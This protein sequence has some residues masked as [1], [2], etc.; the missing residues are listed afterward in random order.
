MCSM[1]D[2]TGYINMLASYPGLPTPAFVACSTNAGEGKYA[3]CYTIMC[4]N[5]YANP[6]KSAGSLTHTY[7][8]T[9][10]RSYILTYSL[11]G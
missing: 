6:G 3:M 7:T 2:D 8:Y 10:S 1:C 4:R 11:L 5:Y 9:F